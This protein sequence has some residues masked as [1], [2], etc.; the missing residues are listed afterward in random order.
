MEKIRKKNYC[1][2]LETL[3]NSQAN[4]RTLHGFQLRA[5]SKKAFLRQFGKPEY[6]VN[7]EFI[8]LNIISSRLYSGIIAN[9]IM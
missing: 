8:Y 3:N 9:S 5:I 1:R 6:V 7:I 2:S 4:M